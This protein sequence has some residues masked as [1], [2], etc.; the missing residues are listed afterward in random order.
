MAVVS[1]RLNSGELKKLPKG[2]YADGNGLWLYKSSEAVGKW[3]LRV[4]VY[5]SRKEMGLGAYS[6]GKG[7]KLKT[8]RQEAAKWRAVAA[9]GLSPIAERDRLKRQAERNLHTLRDVTADAFE[10]RKAELKG[11]GKAG[12]WMSPLEI[13]VLPKLGRTPVSEITQI[14]IRNILSPIWHTKADTARKAMN[15]L[16]LVLKHAA[17]LGLDVDLQA[18]DKARALLGKTRHKPKSIPSMHW[19]DVPDFYQSLNDGGVTHLAL[20]LLILTGVRSLPV[21][22]AKI[23]QLDGTVWTVPG[24]MMKGKRDQTPDFRVPL[25][26]DASETIDA[27]KKLSRDGY[28]FPSVRN[29][30]ISDATMSAYMKRNGYEARPHGF[31]A[32][33]RNWAEEVADA[34]EFVAETSLAHVVGGNVQRKYRTTDVLDKRRALM[35]RWADH[36]AGRTGLVEQLRQ[37]P[38]EA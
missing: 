25:S 37:Y 34:S 16:G 27:A 5:G 2:K 15:R 9:S 38:N 3:V 29:G 7:V 30:V 13:H 12:R 14:E 26:T 4:T 28:L 32:T 20:R 22:F 17:A 35:Q 33:F 36:V 11:D 10:A 6:N 19:Q 24:E 8:A 31:R 1:N 21:R 18:T 23:D